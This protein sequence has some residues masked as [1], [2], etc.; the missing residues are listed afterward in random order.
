[1]A[2]EM[3]DIVDDKNNK[4]G[5]RMLKSQAHQYGKWHRA[6]HTWVYNNRGEVLLQLRAKDKLVY[7]DLWDVAVGG[8]V[9][10]GESEVSSAVREIEEEIG[11]E[12]LE[13]QLTLYKIK[14]FNGSGLVANNEFIYVYTLPYNGGLE[15]LTIQREEVQ[16]LGLFNVDELAQNIRKNPQKYVPRYDYWIEMICKIIE[17]SP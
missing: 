7:P 4:I 11:L 5:L 6:T 15:E 16:R 9:G 13:D 2:D 12:V 14:P 10:M 1:M 17:L 3:I 8:H